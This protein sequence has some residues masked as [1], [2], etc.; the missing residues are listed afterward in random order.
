M[1][2]GSKEPTLRMDEIIPEPSWS[3]L[4]PEDEWLHYGR[5]LQA[6]Q[7]CDLP[8]AVG[9][10]FAFSNYAGK[11]RDTKDLDLYTL[12]ALRNRFVGLLSAHGFQ[13]YHDTAP[14]D[15]A[16]IYRSCR[17]GLIVD[18][19]WR[20]ANYYAE[21]DEAWLTSGPKL[22][23]RGL[24]LP[25]IPPEE[26]VWAKLFVVQRDRC[27][28]PDILNILENSGH[29]LDWERLIQRVGP[30][31][32]LLGS[33]LSVYRWLRPQRAARLPQWIWS[34]VGL[35]PN[36]PVDGGRPELLDR[37]DWFGPS[38]KVAEA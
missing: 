18:V 36:F 38:D 17:D 35:S 30:A 24:L 37:R 23:L 28:W 10:G 21:V 9:G 15:R 7:E 5:V 19:I 1:L 13:D 6:V 3:A 25:L 4:M 12:P 22:L 20:M 29:R 14:Y 8:F 11:W 32:P 34:R 2:N 26:L 33:V 31:A 16:W 27:D